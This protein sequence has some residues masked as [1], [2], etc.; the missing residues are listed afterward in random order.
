VAIEPCR[1]QL[2]EG[3]SGPSDDLRARRREAKRCQR[4][5]R[6]R[7]AVL[8]HYGRACACCGTTENLTVD[9]VN[10]GGNKHRAQIG[11]GSYGF[12]RWLVVNGFPAGFQILCAPCNRSKA[13]RE[14]CRLNHDHAAGLSAGIADDVR[15]VLV[16]AGVG[17]TS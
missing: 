2:A 12:Y 13:D 8:D 7:K 1:L 6:R 9:H 10:G 14:S 3:D 4:H 15:G 11:E 5:A 17:A 16:A